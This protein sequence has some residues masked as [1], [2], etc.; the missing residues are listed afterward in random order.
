MHLFFFGGLCGG[1]FSCAFSGMTK[2][3]SYVEHGCDLGSNDILF[4]VDIEGR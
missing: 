2:A 1:A 4:K 3:W